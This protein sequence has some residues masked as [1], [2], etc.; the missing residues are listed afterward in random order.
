MKCCPGNSS[1]GRR[2][3]RAAGNY[4]SS[5]YCACLRHIPGHPRTRRPFRKDLPSDWIP[6]PECISYE[7][8]K[9]IEDAQQ[10]GLSGYMTARVIMT[11][12]GMMQ[13]VEVI[14]SE[15]NDFFLPA[16]RQL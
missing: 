6:E 16:F 15:P 4:G 12:D 5:E 7:P 14:E 2:Q 3:A 9:K 10:N 8:G 11:R 1:G 13:M